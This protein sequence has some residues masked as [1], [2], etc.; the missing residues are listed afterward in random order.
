MTVTA[1]IPICMEWR[2]NAARTLS[3]LSRMVA[4]QK[5]VSSR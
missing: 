5:S 1:L 2:L 4:M 3:G